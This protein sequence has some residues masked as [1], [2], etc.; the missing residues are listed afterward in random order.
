VTPHAG[1]GIAFGHEEYKQ[2][3]ER[4]RKEEEEKK[5]IQ[6]EEEANRPSWDVHDDKLKGG[7]HRRQAGGLDPEYCKDLVAALEKEFE[8]SLNLPYMGQEAIETSEGPC[9]PY[10]V[11]K[12]TGTKEPKIGFIGHCSWPNLDQGSRRGIPER[13]FA[14]FEGSG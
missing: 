2:N 1:T 4:I 3:L 6:E 9:G 5:R 7:M 14:P 8:D 13:Y 12:A 10:G 11:Q